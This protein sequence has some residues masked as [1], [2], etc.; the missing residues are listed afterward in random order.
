MSKSSSSD[1]LRL[2]PEL[3]ESVSILMVT[4]P[5]VGRVWGFVT[6]DFATLKTGLGMETMLWPLLTVWPIVVGRF[7]TIVEAEGEDPPLVT[8]F[9]LIEDIPSPRADFTIFFV[10]AWDEAARNL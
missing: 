8:N 6:T 9:V 1:R 5:D 2:R 7:L 10:G 4:A 3:S